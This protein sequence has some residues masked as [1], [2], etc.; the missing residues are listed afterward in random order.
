[1][2]RILIIFFL[3]VSCS[4]NQSQNKT[5][6]SNF[7]FSENMSFEQFKIELEEYAKNNP[8]PNINN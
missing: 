6:T 3:L 5:N 2:K 7:T 8:Y 1:M 4:T